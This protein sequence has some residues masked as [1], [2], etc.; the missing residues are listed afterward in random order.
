M[1]LLSDSAVY[2][3]HLKCSL[4]FFLALCVNL[5]LNLW[6]FLSTSLGLKIVVFLKAT[7]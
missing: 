2:A 5:K 3:E 6:C 4:Q 7:Y 1:W